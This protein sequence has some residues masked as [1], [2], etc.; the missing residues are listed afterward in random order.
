MLEEVLSIINAETSLCSMCLRSAELS[1]TDR[2][3]YVAVIG[4]LIL[5]DVDIF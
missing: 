3:T 5:V 4:I 2:L 1:R